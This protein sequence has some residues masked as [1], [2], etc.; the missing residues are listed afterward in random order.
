VFVGALDYRA[1]VDGVHWFCREVWP[2]VC[3]RFADAQFVIVGRRPVRSVRRL[4]RNPAIKV[5]GDTPD[6][7]PYLH[8]ATIVVVPLRIARG[9]QNK[10]LEALAVG[11]PVMASRQAL[12]GLDVVAGR[13]VYQADTAE[14]WLNGVR[15]LFQDRTERCRLGSAGR[16]FIMDHH[17]WDE[18]LQP[19]AKLLGTAP[20][21]Q[22]TSTDVPDHVAVHAV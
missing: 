9:I 1:N 17:Q 22:C 15:F 7:R 5:I 10:V 6:V 13:H 3:K 4:A 19:F 2:H 11:K 16:K 18:C 20:P 21:T 12:E 8:G 14:E